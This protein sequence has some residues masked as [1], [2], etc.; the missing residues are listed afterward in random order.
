[1]ENKL[2]IKEDILFMAF[3]YALGRRTYAVGEVVDS[4]KHNWEHLSQNI[5]DLVKREI[6]SAIQYNNAGME[7]DIKKWNEVL[8]LE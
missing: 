8:N 6:V 7:M 5:K 1:M 2:D 4:L 3:R